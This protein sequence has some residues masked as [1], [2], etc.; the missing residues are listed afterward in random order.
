MYPNILKN[1]AVFHYNHFESTI[2]NSAMIFGVGK[3][4]LARWTKTTHGCL[5]RKESKF[6]KL[7]STIELLLTANPFLTTKELCHKVKGEVK[8]T[9]I[10]RYIRKAGFSRKRT[11][12]KTGPAT[13]GID[14]MSKKRA[15]LRTLEADQEVISVDETCIYLK[16]PP[17]YGYSRRGER[18]TVRTSKMYRSEKVSLVLA[19]SNKRGV[20]GY[21]TCEGC[22]NTGSF[23]QFIQDIDAPYG[24]SLLM[25][26]VRFH[27]AAETRHT[28]LTKGFSL[29]YTPSY[30][31]E[32]NPVEYAF[33]VLKNDY[34]RHREDRQ[35]WEDNITRSL[36]SI[37]QEKINNFYRHV[38]DALVPL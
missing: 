1:R 36:K 15:M 6:T 23:S 8:V 21:K 26:N 25:D 10:R 4:T 34:A 38:Y 32:L 12:G 37:T 14:A 7:I 24:S 5:Q 18:L 35:C 20:V 33:S 29:L 30:S 19:I 31:P 9:S 13:Q 22:F 16:K 28:A 17:S 27:H 11:R 3:S 2:R